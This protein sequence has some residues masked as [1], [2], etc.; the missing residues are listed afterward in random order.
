MLNASAQ[1]SFPWEF[2]TIV[3][4]N[5]SPV[6]ATMMPPTLVSRRRR[7]PNSVHEQ[8]GRE[9]AH[10]LGLYKM[11]A[12]MP[13]ACSKK[14]DPHGSKEHPPDG[15]GWVEEQL[16]PHLFAMGLGGEFDGVGL[17]IL[18][19][20]SCS[21]YVME[22]DIDFF[23]GVGYS[24]Q[25][26]LGVPEAAPALRATLGTRAFSKCQRPM[27]VKELLQYLLGDQVYL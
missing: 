8:G 17:A 6:R 19:D 11:T 7:R 13:V 26:A 9:Y 25:D 4:A 27:L 5:P 14:M 2:S 18:G 12:S 24:Q 21:F 16:L 10:G 1:V 20:P 23:C 15:R 3:K 22:S